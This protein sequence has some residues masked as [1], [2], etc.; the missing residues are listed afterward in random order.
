MGL[1]V[2]QV[3]P[4]ISSMRLLFVPK[5][6]RQVYSAYMLA[7]MCLSEHFM[8]A[9]LVVEH[10]W[11]DFSIPQNQLLTPWV[12][13][14]LPLYFHVMKIRKLQL[15]QE[16]CNEI[17]LHHVSKFGVIYWPFALSRLSICPSRSSERCA[18]TVMLRHLVIGI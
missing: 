7:L 14:P 10:T 8:S 5:L 11:S 12:K 6:G 15:R 16:T 13:C 18:P 4:H 17:V 2:C 9:R 3:A 1:W